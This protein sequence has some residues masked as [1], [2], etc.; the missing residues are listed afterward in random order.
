MNVRPVG[1]NWRPSTFTSTA[2]VWLAFTLAGP[3]VGGAGSRPQIP[4]IEPLSDSPDCP[5]DGSKPFYRWLR[6]LKV[7]LA[8][9]ASLLTILQLLGG[10]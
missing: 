9:V 3:V 4:V 7:I 1:H 2:R 8:I 6:L 10:L 5:P